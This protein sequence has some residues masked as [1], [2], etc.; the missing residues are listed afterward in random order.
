MY[1]SDFKLILLDDE[2][3][4]L[5]LADEELRDKFLEY[6]E[7]YTNAIWRGQVTNQFKKWLKGMKIYEREKERISFYLSEE[8]KNK[9]RQFIK[10]NDEFTSFS[11]LIREAVEF[12]IDSYREISHLDH[13]RKFL[14]NNVA[15]KQSLTVIKGTLDLLLREYSEDLNIRAVNMIQD[16]FEK[17]TLIE[18]NI[19]NLGE[20]KQLEEV[21]LYVIEDEPATMRLIKIITE[22]R[23]NTFKGA[24]NGRRA[25]ETLKTIHPKLIL[26][27]IILPD[28]TG[29][30]ICKYIKS[31]KDLQNLTVYYLAC[32]PEYIVKSK[33]RET[34]ADG[35]ILKPFSY[36]D[37]TQLLEKYTQK[38][39]IK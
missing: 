2:I 34:G 36:D 17:S 24:E 16:A 13:N 15:L 11:K 29:Y 25:I 33:V 23:G 12:Y 3:S 9:W 18:S 10:S 27:D 4:E 14:E 35:Y 22:E 21:D 20:K 28:I 30:D 32:Q 8:L 6:N 37:I 7:I 38:K 19:R 5:G 26:L 39:D 31:D 1:N